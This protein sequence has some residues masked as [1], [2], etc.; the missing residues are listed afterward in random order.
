MSWLNLTY[1]QAIKLNEDIDKIHNP[2]YWTFLAV[3]GVMFLLESFLPVKS[4]FESGFDK[5]FTFFK[6]GVIIFF[7]LIALSQ[8]LTGGCVVQIPQNWI[9]KT[10]LNREYW[11]PYGPVFR[12]LLPERYWFVLQ[13]GYFLGSIYALWRAIEF[14]KKRVM[15]PLKAEVKQ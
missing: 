3:I 10:Y 4:K 1:E 11:Y 7:T 6:W 2:Y 15:I 12:E 5:Y 14:Y 8:G 13:I 9:A